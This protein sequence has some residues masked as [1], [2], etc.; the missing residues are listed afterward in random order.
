MLGLGGG[1]WSVGPGRSA[2]VDEGENYGGAVCS[3]FSLGFLY[4]LR[5]NYLLVRPDD[6]CGN[7]LYLSV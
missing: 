5:V 7:E 6:G 1:A 4:L 3:L 2:R